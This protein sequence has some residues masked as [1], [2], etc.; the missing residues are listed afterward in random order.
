MIRNLLLTTGIV[1]FAS[2]MAFS[3]G[4]TLKGTIIDNDSKEPIPFANIVLEVGGTMVGG[5]SS[6]FDGNYTIKPIPPGTYDLK[7]SSVGFQPVLIT[8]VIINEGKI[9]FFDVK[10]T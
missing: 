8:G 5:T 3:Q 7:A 4:G 6:D 10:M 2:F 9:E 1:L